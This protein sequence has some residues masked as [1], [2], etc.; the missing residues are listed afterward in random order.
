[1]VRE[2]ISSPVLHN[3]AAMRLT[4]AGQPGHVVCG[5]YITLPQGDYVVDFTVALSGEEGAGEDVCAILDVVADWGNTRFAVSQLRRDD[6][7]PDAGT[8]TLDF[9]VPAVSTVEF[10]IETTG[11][12]PLIV[13]SEP[14]LR[15][16]AAPMVSFAHCKEDIYLWRALAG[17]VHHDVGFW[18]DAGAFDPVEA[19]V[20]KAFYDR[21]WRGINIEPLKGPY[22][23]LV[24]QR[25]R[26]INL[27]LLVSDVEGSETFY[28]LDNGQLS[29]TN[30][31]FAR[32]HM[33][34]GAQGTSYTVEATTLGRICEQ[35]AP[36]TI[37]FLKI[38]VEGHEAK[39]IKGM[40]F[41]RF[42][43]WILVLEATE[44][45]RMDRPTHMEWEHMIVA[46]GYQHVRTDLPNRYYVAD[47]H[48]EL[49]DAF[50]APVDEYVPAA[51]LRTV[52]AFEE[53]IASLNDRVRDLEAALTGER[54]RRRRRWS[55]W[56]RPG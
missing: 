39:A 55:G 35:Y 16:R 33:Q 48:P 11:I 40:D 26:D 38:D 43:P 5:Q 19:S 49:K 23:R 52:R 21:G 9:S 56:L 12:A 20:T 36:E 53:R 29:T 31:E 25:P 14:L 44:P 54:D 50:G 51:H 24:E 3:G 22:G 15:Y 46:A 30:E 18:I 10:R 27:Q 1:M 8:F 37:H 34:A 4:R 28:E 45:N 17:R 6:L 47:E 32:R 7:A 41:D 13:G 42:R 2:D